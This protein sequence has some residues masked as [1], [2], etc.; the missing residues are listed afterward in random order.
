M[1]RS[2]IKEILRNIPSVEVFAQRINCV[3]FA[4]V[5]AKRNIGLD[6]REHYGFTFQDEILYSVSYTKNTQE[7]PYKKPTMFRERRWN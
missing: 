6:I 1:N 7:A 3:G 5:S 4:Q 2:K